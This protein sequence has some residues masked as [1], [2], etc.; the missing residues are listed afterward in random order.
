MNDI[1]A[2]FKPRID[3]AANVLR[4]THEGD[5]TGRKWVT[6]WH[7]SVLQHI[8]GRHGEDKVW[9]KVIEVVPK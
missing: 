4:K 1:E 5:E 2:R 6:I 3:E 9:T 7:R 8:V